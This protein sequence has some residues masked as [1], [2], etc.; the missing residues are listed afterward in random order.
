[1]TDA[2]APE[3]L[4]AIERWALVADVG[5]TN[6]RFALVDDGAASLRP[7]AAGTL[8]VADFASLADAATHYLQQTL[9][10]DRGAWPR[11]AAMALATAITGDAVRMTNSPWSFSI[12]GLRDALG[13]DDLCLLNDFTALAWSVLTL[14]DDDLRQVGG[15]RPVVDQARGL[16]GPGT[17]LGVSGL[18]P[19]LGGGW[20]ALQGEGGHCSLSPADAREA[21]ILAQAWQRYPH[22]SFERLVCGMG[23][24]LLCEA[25]ARVDGLPM[26]EPEGGAVTPAWITSRALAGDP[27][28]DATMRTFCAMLGSAAGNLALVLGAR[29]G[30]YIGGGIIPRLGEWFD[31]TPF[32]QRFESKG[33][34]DD[35]LSRIPTYVISGR[36]RDPALIGAAYA[37]LMASPR[38]AAAR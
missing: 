10:Q 36:T 33:R 19:V 27:L 25:V 13:L 26:P 3:R 18:I 16:I 23:L 5:G 12:A 28:C 15:G 22:V 17:G 29:G 9:G 21:A 38:I 8:P 4:V 30:I 31:A 20:A 14:Q 35:Y 34:F 7:Q 37:L 6:A 11:R 24:P 32:R 1:M 2:G